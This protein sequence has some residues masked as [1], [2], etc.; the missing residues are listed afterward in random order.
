MKILP[1]ISGWILL[2]LATH[3][4]FAEEQGESWTQ[5]QLEIIELTRWVAMAPKQAGYQA[6][7]DLFYPDFTNWYMSGDKTSLRGR[8]EYLALVKDWLSAG[9]HATYSEVDTISVDVIGDIAYIRQIKEEHF[10]HPDQPATKFV[11]HFASLFKKHKGKWRFYRT[12]FD[13]R[14]R[15]PLDGSDITINSP[16]ADQ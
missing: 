6:Y 16:K 8:E 15:G 13:T 12:S 7:A 5:E 11:G 1:K 3:S 9:N 4:I 2:L 10:Q 14:Y